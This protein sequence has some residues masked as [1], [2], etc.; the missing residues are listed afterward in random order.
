M[1][2]FSLIENIS[3]VSMLLPF[4]EISVHSNFE[5]VA[6]RDIQLSKTFLSKNKKKKTLKNVIYLYYM[7]YEWNSRIILYYINLLLL[8]SFLYTIDYTI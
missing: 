5:I 3:N 7:I 6:G 2:L 8:N 4:E 1:F